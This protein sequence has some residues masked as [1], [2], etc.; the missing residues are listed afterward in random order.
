MKSLKFVLNSFSPIFVNFQFAYL[1]P[2]RKH[3]FRLSCQV[4]VKPSQAWAQ[5]KS[6]QYW[7][8]RISY[9]KVRRRSLKLSI[10]FYDKYPIQRFKL[11]TGKAW[12][13]GKLFCRQILPYALVDLLSNV[14]D[15]WTEITRHYWSGATAR[16]S[17]FEALKSTAKYINKFVVDF[18]PYCTASTIFTELQSAAEMSLYHNKSNPIQK[19]FLIPKFIFTF[20]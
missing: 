14:H 8:G 9:S 1:F 11:Y 12:I 18:A 13:I 5:T 7:L 6:M 17:L 4:K 20:T 10:G 2:I 19:S 15:N 16:V 3:T